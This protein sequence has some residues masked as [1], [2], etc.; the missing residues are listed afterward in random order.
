MQL[1]ILT[2]FIRTLLAPL[3]DLILL[4][5]GI[6]DWAASVPALTLVVF[7]F[8]VLLWGDRRGVLGIS[9]IGVFTAAFNMVLFES[10]TYGSSFGG[11]FIRDAFADFFI[12][13]ILIVGVL[14]LMSATLYGGE[15]SSYNFLLLMSF[16]GAIWVVMAT[17]LVALFLAWELMSTPTYVLVA[18]GPHRGSVDGATKYFVMGLLSTMLMIFGIALVIGVTGTTL[19]SGANSIA[20]A[21]EA[22]WTSGTAG[23]AAYSL[24]LAMIMFVI[25]FGFKVGIFPGWMWVPDAYSTADGSVTGYLAGATKK[26]GISALMRILM[27]AFFVARMEW[28]F[29]IVIVSILTMII[30]NVLALAERNIMRMLAYSSIVMMGFVFVGIAAGTQFGAAAGMFHAFTHAL[31]KTGAFILIWAMSVRLAKEIT[32]DDL[33]GLGKRAPMAAAMFA[34][35]IF[36]LAGGPLTVGFWS[37]WIFL[38]QSAVEANLWWFALVAL[39]NSVFSLGY[40]LRVLRYMYMMEPTTNTK[41]ELARIPM[42]AVGLCVIA[43]I[44][45]FVFPGIVLDYAFEGAASLI[46]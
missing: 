24:L 38:P 41:I 31:M 29:I 13:I 42:I 25:A 8:I 40:Y 19:L 20:M 1:E 35:L 37:K 15:R 34:V 14:I 44:G 7:S 33:A 46:P 22:I 45:L 17:D 36:A 12:W 30:G 6:E 27:V 10:G 9:I 26:T 32:Y 21:I 16:A 2:D 18:L 4:V 3:R 5:P 43:I 23:P 28:M 39:F 11:L